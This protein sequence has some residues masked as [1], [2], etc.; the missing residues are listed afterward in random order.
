MRCGVS[1]YCSAS[2][3]FDQDLSLSQV[4]EDLVVEKFNPH[5][6]VAIAVRYHGFI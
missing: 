5:P 3:I 4:V 1:W 2:S 6:P